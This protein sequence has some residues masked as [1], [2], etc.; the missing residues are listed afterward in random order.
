M[1]NQGDDCYFFFYSTCTKGDSC[2]FRHCEA[3]LGMKQFAGLWQEGRCSPPNMQVRHMEIDKKR[4]EIACYWENQISGCQKANCAFH[5]TK[6]RFVDGA[7][8][9]PS[10]AVAKPEPSDP[11][12]QTSVLLAAPAKLSGAPTPQ[13][14]GVKKMEATENVPSPTHPPVVINAA[15]DDED[16]D[17]FCPTCLV[18][19][20]QQGTTVVSTRKS[21]TPRKDVDL[22]YGIKTL[23]EIK[24]EKQKNQGVANDDPLA[25]PEIL[26][27]SF[28]QIDSSISVLRTVKF[29]NKD[30]TTKL[31]LAQRLGKRK[32]FHENSSIGSASGEEVLPSV[33]KTL[34]ERLGK[35]I[36]PPTDSPECLPKK[37]QNPR[38]VKDRL[39]LPQEQS[40]TQMETAATT[41]TDFHIK[42]LEEIRQEKANQRLEQETTSLPSESKDKICIKNKLSSKTQTGIYIK[43][44]GEIQAEKRLRQLKDGIQKRENAKD[45]LDNKANKVIG[46]T[47]GNTAQNNTIPTDATQK[48]INF[49]QKVQVERQ[50][51]QP[52]VNDNISSSVG[53]AKALSVSLKGPKQSSQSIEKVRVKTLEEIRQEKAFRLQQTAKSENVESVSQPQ[54]PPKHKMSLRFSKIPGSTEAKMDQS[55]AEPSLPTNKAAEEENQVSM[56]FRSPVKTSNKE[57]SKK[58]V[59]T[60]PESGAVITDFRTSALT[61]KSNA[62]VLKSTILTVQ[63]KGKPKLNVE[64]CVVK[65][66]LPVK[67]AMKQKAQERTIV[68]EVKPMNSAVTC[69]EG[70]RA[71]EMLPV[72]DSSEEPSTDCIPQKRLKISSQASTSLPSASV[73]VQPALKSPRTSTASVGKTSMSTEDEFDELMWE[74][75]DDKLEAELELDSN[76]D[77]DAL[78]LELSKMIDS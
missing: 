69:S 3:A 55:T 26:V 1:S 56:T 51:K 70:K 75:S 16:D 24:S 47:D 59:D 19:E 6:G 76:K 10:K 13:I 18:P 57:P 2:A 14:R 50:F 72:I 64:P 46:H 30:S 66:P 39:G 37:V 73:T 20:N 8:F 31:S 33:K 68:A 60:K 38:L 61:D 53:T 52:L 23:K 9:P 43:S 63:K 12:V 71:A 25:S 49:I 21:L 41:A 77:E 42:T 74:I 48:Q 22:N 17:E 5:H 7:Y 65:N 11:D 40:S 54:A 78:L 62:E 15:D 36:T 27:S 29:T 58:D 67:A 44:L 45:D 32:T 34:S 4:S 35:R 28:N